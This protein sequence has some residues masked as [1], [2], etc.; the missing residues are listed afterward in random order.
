MCGSTLP[1]YHQPDKIWALGGATYNKWIAKPRHIGLNEPFRSDIDVTN[2]E[3]RLY[4]IAGA[5]MLV[6]RSFL[7]DIGLIS[8]N[9]FIYFEELDWAVRARCCYRMAYASE[10]IV[11]HKVGASTGFHVSQ[12]DTRMADYFM[13]RNSILF[14]Y[15]YYPYALPFVLTRVSIIYIVKMVLSSFRK[16]LAIGR[17]T[18]RY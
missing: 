17:N 1:Y 16:L 8:E 2:I 5:S 13:F 12:K 11:Y 10:S 15:K 6:S 9:Y 18:S 4:Y 3:K 7:H 14:T